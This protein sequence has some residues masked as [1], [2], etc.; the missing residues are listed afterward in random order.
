MK[1]DLYVMVK[2]EVKILPYFLRHYEQFVERMY[3]W[4]DYSDD[5]SRE[6]LNAHPKVR[7]IDMP[8][9]G[10]DDNYARIN[11][12]TK[13]TF[14]SRG[15][16]DWVMCVDVDEFLYHPQMLTALE[17]YQREGM[18]LI[19]PVGFL[20]VADEF[21]QSGGQIYDTI[22]YGFRD[23]TM[24]KPIIFN[25]ELDMVFSGGRHRTDV[26]RRSFIHYP[27]LTVRKRRKSGVK[28]LHYRFF[29]IDDYIERIGRNCQRM[30]E[31]GS[32]YGKL[33]WPFSENM[34][35]RMPDYSKEAPR[36]WFSEHKH[37]VIKVID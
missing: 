7:L 5:G 26:C 32:E 15:G 1:I 10:I 25:P 9:R 29:G 35:W 31:S 30:Y 21:P 3:V 23:K 12:F 8:F 18:E 17:Q 19:M 34:K 20:M 28:C 36:K 2:N 27:D 22:K 33:F 37:E 4:D 14:F 16:A 11:F 6:L 24:D 13:Y